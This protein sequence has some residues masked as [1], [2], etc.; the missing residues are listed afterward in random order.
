MSD[1]FHRAI[2]IAKTAKNGA[3]QGRQATGAPAWLR[4]WLSCDD[5]HCYVV[6]DVLSVLECYAYAY[7]TSIDTIVRVHYTPVLRC[8]HTVYT[9]LCIESSIITKQSII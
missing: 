3:K 9:V 4:F 7:K 8:C 5:G 1:T 2:A 6:D